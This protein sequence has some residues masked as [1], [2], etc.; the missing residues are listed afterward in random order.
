MAP[1][2]HVQAF[3]Y[4]EKLGYLPSGSCMLVPLDQ[5]EFGGDKNKHMCKFIAVC[6]TMRIVEDVRWDKDVVYN[7]TW[8]LLCEVTKHNQMCNGRD[9]IKTIACTGLATGVGEW[10]TERCAEQMAL[11]IK[12]FEEAHNKP[13]IFKSISWADIRGLDNELRATY[14]I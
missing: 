13:E 1:T 4:K 14:S 3:L 8:N 6:P 11:A 2:K 5:S 7:C 12:H 9:V 10:S